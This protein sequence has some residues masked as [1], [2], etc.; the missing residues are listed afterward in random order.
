MK[1]AARC[2]QLELRRALPISRDKV[3]LTRYE[4]ILSRVQI[5]DRERS[6]GYITMDSY[7]EQYGNP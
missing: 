1:A 6:G 4:T 5:W 7:R 3:G 2:G